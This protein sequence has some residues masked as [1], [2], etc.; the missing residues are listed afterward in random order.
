MYPVKQ[1]KYSVIVVHNMRKN[2]TLQTNLNLCCSASRQTAGGTKHTV[3]VME[4][5]SCGSILPQIKNHTCS[6]Y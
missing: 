1:F 5:H 3:F 2:K 4:P 6:A